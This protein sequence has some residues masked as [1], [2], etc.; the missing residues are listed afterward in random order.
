MSAESV[1]A[2]SVSAEDWQDLP[3]GDLLR[4][5]LDDIRRGRESVAAVL[6]GIAAVVLLLGAGVGFMFYAD[7][8]DERQTRQLRG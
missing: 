6:L 3:G 2:E 4:Q 7:R 5:G 1:S 8:R